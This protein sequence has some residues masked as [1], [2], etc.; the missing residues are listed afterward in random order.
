MARPVDRPTRADL[1][2][3]S[4][5]LVVAEHQPITIMTNAA[6]SPALGDPAAAG[7]TGT[8]ADWIVQSLV[9]SVALVAVFAPLAVVRYRRS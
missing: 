7:L 2:A 4:G 1:G 5:R 6:R 8:T 9:W 3:P